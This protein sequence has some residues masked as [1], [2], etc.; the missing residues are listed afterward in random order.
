MRYFVL[1]LLTLIVAAL[2]VAGCARVTPPAQNAPIEEEEEEVGEGGGTLTTAISVRPTQIDPQAAPNAGLEMMLP[3]LFDTL[4]VRADDGN[5]VP[6]LA[7]NWES[8]QDGRSITVK[9]RNDVWFHDGSRLNAQAVKFT[10]E[11]F[12]TSGQASPLY[13]RILAIAEIQV[14]DDLTVRFVLDEPASDFWDAMSSPMAGI[15]SPE[16]AV[17]AKTAGTGEMIGSGPFMRV[18]SDDPQIIALTRY[19]GYHW[20]PAVT[21]N[22]DATFIENVVLR[23]I[24]DSD[25]QVTALETGQLDAIYVTEAD[26]WLRLERDPSVQLIAAP[27][28]EAQGVAVARQIN[29]VKIGGRGQML[30]NDAKI[31]EK[32]GGD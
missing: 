9:L 12:K 27:H 30:L 14:L 24:P 3:Y 2:V 15:L 6:S 18:D 17:L 25:R 19:V 4:V 8:S 13:P 21:Q 1:S 26:Q 20:G 10:F 29:G 23:V 28:A 22:R 11:R 31:D 7:T 16:A 5:L 32:P